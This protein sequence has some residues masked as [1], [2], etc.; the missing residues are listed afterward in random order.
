MDDAAMNDGIMT[1][2][3]IVA[4]GDAGF[5]IGAMYDDAILD[6]YFIADADAVD[7]PAHDGI[8]PDAAVVAHLHVSYDSSVRRD[9]TIFSKAW[10]LTFHR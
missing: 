3:H 10:C 7:I 4:D 8:E 5:F 1:D 9:K 6:I 2:G